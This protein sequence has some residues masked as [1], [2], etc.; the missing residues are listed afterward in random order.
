MRRSFSPNI[1]PEVSRMRKLLL[2]TAAL[3][4]MTVASNAA[5][6]LI[7]DLGLDPNSAAGAFSNNVGGTTFNDAYTF[8]LD[9]SMTLTIASL[10]NVFPSPTDFIKNFTAS[11]VSGTLAA[12]GAVVLGPEMGTLGC[13]V[14][15]QCQGMAGVAVLGAGSYFLDVTGIGG[16]TSGYGGNIATLAV[17]API[18]G[19][20]IPGILAAFGLGGWGFWRKRKTV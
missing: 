18:V 7:K 17:P 20:G 19:A 4:T 15:T 6:I 11:V 13:G 12:P 2:A 9:H 16:G 5:P 10:T 3:V 1:K 8:T 14:I